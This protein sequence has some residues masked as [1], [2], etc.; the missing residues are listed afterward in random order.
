MPYPEQ[1]EIKQKNEEE[2]LGRFGKLERILGMRYPCFYRNKVTAA[3][4]KDKKGNIKADSN[5]RDYENIPLKENIEDGIEYDETA[6]GRALTEDD[7]L[8][9]EDLE[10]GS[11]YKRFE[12]IEYFG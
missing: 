7:V 10:D 6:E 4:G 2:L 11:F 3:F 12:T 9:H 5:K 1:L 8:I